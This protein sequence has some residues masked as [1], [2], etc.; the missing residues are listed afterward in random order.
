MTTASILAVGTEI[1]DGQ[2]INSNAQWLSQKLQDLN[3]DVSLHLG[4]PD[5]PE[6]IEKTL[7]LATAHTDLIFVCGGL[8]P[9]SDD[10]TRNVISDYLQL[11]LEL[12][13]SAWSEVQEKLQSRNVI[14]REAHQQQCL[15]PKTAKVLANTAG[16]APGFYV[17]KQNKHFW[18]LPGPPHE[19]ESIWQNGVEQQ[20]RSQFSQTKHLQLA[21]W[22]CLGA[23]E[24]ELAHTAE[25]FFSE[26][27]FEKKLGYRLQVPYVEIKLW[28]DPKN[29]DAPSAI[30]EF[31]KQL[32]SFYVDSS[33]LLINKRIEQLLKK[34]TPLLIQDASSSGLLLTRLT[35]ALGAPRWEHGFEYHLGPI[36][37]AP[38]T[39]SRI[40]RVST[41]EQQ[42]TC[43]WHTHGKTSKW[44][45]APPS[46][47]KS[48]WRE[49]YLVEK[50][51]LEWLKE[52]R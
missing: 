6:L 28:H 52:L 38:V 47:K 18:V 44:E 42:W 1:T 7:E 16:I 30:S 35:Q 22:L 9:T 48:K 37:S 2:I 24:S 25:T 41:H 12:S 20:L 36:S 32:G 5:T 40:L 23:P 46:N 15:F 34:Q 50:L 19:I 49:S 26:F 13:A 11:P 4:A 29:K 8:G 17:Q 39:D 27:T 21:T 45:V 31:T 3:I 43:E 51:I 33:L 14:V 10:L